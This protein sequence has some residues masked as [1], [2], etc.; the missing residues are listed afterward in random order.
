V[1]GSTNLI[2]MTKPDNPSDRIHDSSDDV[3]PSAKNDDDSR[4]DGPTAESREQRLK[5][6]QADVAAGKYDSDEML[7]RALEIMLRKLSDSPE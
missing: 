4:S 7:D 1:S 5:R 2:G 6:I 3:P